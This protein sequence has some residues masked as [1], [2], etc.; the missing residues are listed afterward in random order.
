MCHRHLCGSEKHNFNWEQTQTFTNPQNGSISVYSSNYQIKLEKALL[1]FDFNQEKR[2]SHLRTQLR[3][4]QDDMIGKNNLLW[5]TVSEKLNDVYTLKNAGNS[6]AHKSIAAINHEERGE[7]RK[8]GIKSP[9][10]LFS[11]KY[12]SPASIKEL[13]KNP[14]TPKRVHFVNS[15]VILSTDSDE[16]EENISSTNAH[17]HELGNM[18]T[19]GEEVKE[20]GKEEDE[21]ETDVEVEE[22]IDEEESKFKTDKEVKEIFKEAEEDEDDENFNSFSTMKEL[23]HHERLLKNPRPSWVK[24]KIRAGSLNNIK[25]PA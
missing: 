1:D 12:L 3:Q 20:Q 19:R 6:M 23:S 22:L 2:L 17:E 16:E 7:L 5:K 8:K 15:I 25:I 24:A 21:M 18:V 9:S 4:Q 14:S 13:N 10:K 11:L